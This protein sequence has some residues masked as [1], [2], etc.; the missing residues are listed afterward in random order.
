MNKLNHFSKNGILIVFQL[1]TFF[2]IGCAQQI[3][4]IPNDYAFVVK[5]V[6]GKNV[7]LDVTWYKDC[8]PDGSGGYDKSMRTMSGHELS[9]TIIK[10]NSADCKSGVSMITVFVQTLTSDNKQVPITWTDAAGK[11]SNAPAGLEKIKTGNGAT[12]VVTYATIT[13]ITKEQA[14]GLNYIKMGGFTD[15][16]AGTTKDMLPY[17]SAIGP[18]KGTVVVDDRTKIGAVYDGISTNPKEYPT[19]MPNTPPHKGKLNGLKF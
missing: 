2:T 10:Y 7:M 4:K 13:P 11:P 9:T 8:L 5:G 15:W 1:F 14:D 18:M 17:F 3:A 6:T 16:A 19:L 12:G